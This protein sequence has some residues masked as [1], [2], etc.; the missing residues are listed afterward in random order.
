MGELEI[1]YEFKQIYNQFED[2]II[3]ISYQISFDESQKNVYS[4]NIAELEL[5]IFTQIEA[6][7]KY[8]ATQLNINKDKY[9]EIIPKLDYLRNND[10]IVTLG[11]YN[12]EKKIYENMFEKNVDRIKI[13]DGNITKNGKKNYKFN[14]AYQNL[15]HNFLESFKYY[16]TIEYLFESMACLTAILKINNSTLFSV[17]DST[18]GY[19]D[20]NIKSGIRKHYTRK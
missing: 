13:I 3:K 5:R 8:I 20:I 18:G 1:P 7:L 12:L 10:F 4:L 15:R 6:S 2:E 19:F 14:N 17:I 9:D 16:G 11:S